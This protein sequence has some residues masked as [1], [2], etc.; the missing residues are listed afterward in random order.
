[1]A[2][3]HLYAAIIYKQRTFLLFSHKQ[4]VSPVYLTY[5]AVEEAIVEA[6]S[7]VKKHSREHF[8]CSHS[9]NPALYTTAVGTQDELRNIG[10]RERLTARMTQGFILMN[11]FDIPAGTLLDDTRNPMGPIER[12]REFDLTL[13]GPTLFIASAYEKLCAYLRAKDIG[14]FVSRIVVNPRKLY[15]VI[16]LD[17][18]EC[19]APFFDA[20]LKA[21]M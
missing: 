19:V 8:S 21:S 15:I 1:M 14:Q 9:E 11:R 20:L 12:K 4:Y 10:L 6:G 5:V 17:E 3:I 16:P 2:C 18:W 13:C 7:L